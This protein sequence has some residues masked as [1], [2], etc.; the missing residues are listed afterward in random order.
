MALR[1]HGVGE[2]IGTETPLSKEAS[3]T[4][5]EED[6]EALNAENEE[7]EEEGK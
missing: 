6:S 3:A 4:W 5:S 2:V 1:K 7:L